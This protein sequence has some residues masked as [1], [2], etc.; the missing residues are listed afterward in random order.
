MET[1]QIF[2]INKLHEKT[3]I[4]ILREYAKKTYQHCRKITTK[5]TYK[6]TDDEKFYN[7]NQFQM[8]KLEN[9]LLETAKI[10]ERNITYKPQKEQ[11]QQII[12]DLKCG[13][14]DFRRPLLVEDV[15][16]DVAYQYFEDIEYG[17]HCEEPLFHLEYIINKFKPIV[18]T[19]CR[20]LKENDLN[21]IYR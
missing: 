1:I 20:I 17:E 6:T 9:I 21:K 11:L 3:D 16:N 18:N 13:N 15:I 14:N 5:D 12:L 7:N 10:L 19:I 8:G 4:E 2:G